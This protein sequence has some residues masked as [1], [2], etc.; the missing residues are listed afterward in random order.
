MQLGRA[1]F[2]AALLGSRCLAELDTAGR[3][4]VEKMTDSPSQ[5]ITAELATAADA[6]W[7]ADQCVSFR[8]HTTLWSCNVHV[9]NTAGSTSILAPFSINGPRQRRQEPVRPFQSPIDE[10]CLPEGSAVASPINV[11]DARPW[12]TGA[13]A[14]HPGPGRQPAFQ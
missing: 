10:P 14:V 11:M 2:R 3:I 8:G 5:E 7:E 6:D 13:A 1:A 12:A 9:T 4:G